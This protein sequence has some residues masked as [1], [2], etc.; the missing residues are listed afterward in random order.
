MTSIADINQNPDIDFVLVTG[1]LADNGD[2]ASLEQLDSALKVR[3]NYL[4]QK[5]PEDQTLSELYKMENDQLKKIE[6]WNY[7]CIGCKKWYKEKMDECPICG[8]PMRS[9]RKR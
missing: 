4:R 1:D 5:Y 3:K 9:H 6:R 8:S 7:Q 2:N